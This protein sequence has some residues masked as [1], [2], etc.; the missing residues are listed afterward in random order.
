MGHGTLKLNFFAVRFPDVQLPVVFRQKASDEAL[1]P[2]E[3]GWVD[4]PADQPGRQS[5]LK[6]RITTAVSVG[7]SNPAYQYQTKTVS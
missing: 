5:S 3:C 7:P 4:A 1:L 2:T 6:P